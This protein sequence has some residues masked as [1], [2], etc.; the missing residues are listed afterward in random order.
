MEVKELT[1]ALWPDLERL[2]GPRGACG[3]CWCMYWRLPE[4]KKWEE[5]KGAA[6]KR[7]FK[8]LVADGAARGLLAFAE[9]EPV[10]WCTF[11]PRPDFARLDR[12][13]SLACDDADRVWSIPCFFVKGGHRG[14]GVAGALLGGACAAMKRA[15]ARVV[16]GYPVR[17]SRDGKPIPAAFAWT[18]TLSLFRRAGFRPAGP[19]G[20]GKRRMR[21]VL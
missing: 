16:E 20:T 11:G 17:D 4:G 1:P 18:G 3:G 7:C 12:A 15:G 9:G 8:R 13:P 5:F 2:F 10:G 21:K 19:R 14:K 6:A